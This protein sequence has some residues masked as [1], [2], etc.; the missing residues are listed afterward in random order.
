[1]SMRR[2]VFRILEQLAIAIVQQFIT[3]VVYENPILI[4]ILRAPYSHVEE[5]LRKKLNPKLYIMVFSR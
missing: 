4:L 1:M 5:G 2:I 3:V